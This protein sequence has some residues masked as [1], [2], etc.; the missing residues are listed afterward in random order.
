MSEKI[1]LSKNSF[2]HLIINDF[3]LFKLY[4]TYNL[5]KT[6]NLKLNLNNL[7]DLNEEYSLKN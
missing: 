1:H 6:I 5:N 4:L 2:H 3:F 7:L